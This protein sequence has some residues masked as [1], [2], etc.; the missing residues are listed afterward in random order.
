MYFGEVIII[1]DVC[2]N[3]I[4]ARVQSASILLHLQRFPGP[5]SGI[6]RWIFHKRKWDDEIQYLY[7][8]MA[9]NNAWR[10]FMPQNLKC[11]WNLSPTGWQTHRETRLR[12]FETILFFNLRTE[13]CSRKDKVFLIP[14]GWME[15]F[16]SA[17]ICYIVLRRHFKSTQ[18]IQI[19]WEM[20]DARVTM[21][22]ASVSRVKM[23]NRA[24][25]FSSG[26]ACYPS[27]AS[28]VSSN[29]KNSLKTWIKND[30]NIIRYSSTRCCRSLIYHCEGRPSITSCARFF[31]SS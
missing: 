25:D 3:R 28:T 1:D 21:S 26:V 4:T 8:I 6:A 22:A 16:F 23:N 13:N 29:Y 27:D 19:R 5:K 11:N 31:S 9:L 20:G 12:A 7:S 10:C 15:K 17:Q 18:K 30:Q 2:T 14:L 24:K